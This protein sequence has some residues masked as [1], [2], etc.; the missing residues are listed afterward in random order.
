MRR[1]L[2]FRP[3]SRHNARMPVA[4]DIPKRRTRVIRA[5]ER[6]A[7]ASHCYHILSRHTP[8]QDMVNRDALHHGNPRSC[9]EQETTFRACIHVV[10]I[11]AACGPTSIGDAD[12]GVA[13]PVTTQSLSRAIGAVTK[14]PTAEVVDTSAAVSYTHLTLPTNREV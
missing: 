11:D 3:R 4:N 12:R 13:T 2:A 9:A 6:R 14:E 10:K 7:D 8:R 5:G 1:R